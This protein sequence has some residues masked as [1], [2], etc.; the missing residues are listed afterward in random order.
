MPISR[1][2]ILAAMGYAAIS[3]PLELVVNRAAARTLGLKL[4]PQLLARA[5]RVIE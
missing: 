1:R 4:S 3:W 2:H 5:D